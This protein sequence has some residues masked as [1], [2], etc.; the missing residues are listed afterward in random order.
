M[1]FTQEQYHNDKGQTVVYNKIIH[2][3]EP[4]DFP[5]FMGIGFI[6]FM[7]PMGP[8]EQR[9]EVPIKA[10]TVEEAFALFEETM[11]RDG[12]KAV[13]AFKKRVTEAAKQQASKIITPGT[14]DLPKFQGITS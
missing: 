1:I 5:M 6:S 11:E 9:L 4:L 3:Y 8:Q 12:P 13:E 14:T 7:T 10:Q 2:G